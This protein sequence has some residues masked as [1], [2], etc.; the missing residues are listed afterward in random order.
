MKT[1][2]R[3][4]ILLRYF[5]KMFFFIRRNAI[6]SF[7]KLYDDIHSNYKIEANQIKCFFQ[8]FEDIHWQI[9]K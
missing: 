5:Q 8:N 9:K 1:V 7:G 4:S 3:R 2:S 6:F